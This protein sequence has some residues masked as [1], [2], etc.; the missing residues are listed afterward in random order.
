MFLV[1]LPSISLPIGTRTTAN[2]LLYLQNF[3]YKR[4][5]ISAYGGSPCGTEE[6][7]LTSIHEDMGLISGLA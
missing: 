7:N 2:S 1:L 6:M 5:T 4:D 3:L